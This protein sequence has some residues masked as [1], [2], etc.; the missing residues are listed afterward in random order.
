M[1]KSS[2]QKYQIS[3]KIFLAVIVL[4]ISIL[5]LLAIIGVIT[6]FHLIYALSL[7]K[8]VCSLGKYIPQVYLNF[9]RKSTVGWSILNVLL[10]LS[11]GILSIMQQV[12]DC[13]I[14]D[15]WTLITE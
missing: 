12:L 2:N 4:L 1:Y 10:D 6:W 8:V 14:L 7:I 11:G 5:L 9:K 13:V 3:T 15:D